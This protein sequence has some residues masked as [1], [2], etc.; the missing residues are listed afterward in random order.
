MTRKGT[1]QPEDVTAENETAVALRMWNDNDLR[2]IEDFDD[3]LRL[4]GV[5]NLIK[6]TDIIGSGFE[7]LGEK[8]RLLDVPFVALEW[9]FNDG[10]YKDPSTGEYRKFV[11]MTIVTRN[12]I[13]DHG[14]NGRKW[15]VNDGSTG[16]AAQ[17]SD[18]SER[19]NVWGGV[20][21]EK[22]LRVSRYEALV[23]GEMQPAETYYLA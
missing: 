8:D 20:Y 17:L 18:A 16:I 14:I 11:S 22:G 23:D 6:S 13:R 15:I 7:V 9:R 3:A 19:S 10:K 4:V 2:G 12:E 5:D 21:F 1:D